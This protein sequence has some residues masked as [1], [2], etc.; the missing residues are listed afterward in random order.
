MQVKAVETPKPIRFVTDERLDFRHSTQFQKSYIIGSSYRSGSTFLCWQLWQTG[1]LGAPCE[2]FSPGL[3]LGVLM[4]RFNVFT[5]KDY[6]KKLMERRTS[7]NGVLGMK[8]HFHYFAAFLKD[9]PELLD[10]LSPVNYIYISRRDKV[11][12]AVSMAKAIQTNWWS[13]RMEEGPRPPLKYDRDMI[14]NCLKEIDLQDAGWL[15][16]F[17][18]KKISPHQLVYEDMIADTPGTVRGIM[19]LLDVEKDPPSEVKVPPAE[20]QSDETNTEW[21]KR[22]EEELRTGGNRLQESLGKAETGAVPAEA[23]STEATDDRHFCD[24]YNG[25]VK[26]S[27]VGRG[28]SVTGFIEGVRLRRRYDV[29]IGGN[30]N[31]FADARVLDIQS[32]EG[33]WCLAALDAG[34]A[35]VIGVDSSRMHIETAQTNFATYAIRSNKFELV[36]SEI[37]AGLRQYK[38]RDFD[39]ILCRGFVERCNIPELFRHLIRL[40]PKHV[41]LDTKV[42]PGTRPMAKFSTATTAAGVKGTIISTPTPELITFLSGSDFRCRAMDWR[43]MGFNDWTGIHDYARG[44]H[45]TFVLE[46]LP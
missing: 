35:H 28:S 39:L 30:R 21:I 41:I 8:E 1:V 17:D 40:R 31:L 25:L 24:R 36:Q 37:F 2:Y 32:S 14:S 15:R 4:K 23:G 11:A 43:S 20:K 34:A 9:F 33:F 22:F 10:V 26:C 45:Q 46:R 44:S 38:P 18:S 7:Q 29:I 6:V 19:K 12:Q 5:S 16:W 3:V 13:S 27:T 42:V